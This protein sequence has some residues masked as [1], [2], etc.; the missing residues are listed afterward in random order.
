MPHFL[1]SKQN[2]NRLNNVVSRFSSL[3]NIYHQLFTHMTAVLARLFETFS[4]KI[5]FLFFSFKYWG[6]KPRFYH[7][8]KP[9]K[10][11][12][13]QIFIDN[14]NNQEKLY[15]AGIKEKQ[16]KKR[17]TKRLVLSLRGEAFE[18]AKKKL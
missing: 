1:F 8:L 12:Q 14:I 4:S 16:S 17:D 13:K 2:A 10:K 11:D 18:E 5:C 15:K 9:T 3:F 6:K 7:L